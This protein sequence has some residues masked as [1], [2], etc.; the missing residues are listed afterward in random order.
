MSNTKSSR[1]AS[2]T[3]PSVVGGAAAVA[4]AESA[5][6]VN[7]G[8]Q[9]VGYKARAGAGKRHVEAAGALINGLDSPLEVLEA[10]E[11]VVAELCRAAAPWAKCGRAP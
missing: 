1:H 7:D 2:T 5:P 4:D 3:F 8:D 11:R 6:I 9:V 10:G